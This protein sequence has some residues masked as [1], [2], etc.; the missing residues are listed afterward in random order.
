MQLS[1]ETL[2]VAMEEALARPRPEP[3]PEL[4]LDGA[5]RVAELLLEL[6]RS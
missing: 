2:V 3:G 4:R 6:A 1:P 5:D